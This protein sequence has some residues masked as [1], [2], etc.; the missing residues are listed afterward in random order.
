MS[1]EDGEC[2]AIRCGDLP[3]FVRCN[4]KSDIHGL[5]HDDEDTHRDGVLQ[6]RVG[7]EGRHVRGASLPQSPQVLLQ[8]RELPRD[9]GDVRHDPAPASLRRK[10]AR[11][12]ATVSSKSIHT[13]IASAR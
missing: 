11:C 13:E 1:L 3:A 8:H 12:G 2:V 5:L 4:V 9:Q 10:W 6:Q 7:R